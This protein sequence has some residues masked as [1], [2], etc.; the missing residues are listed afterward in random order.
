MAWDI[1]PVPFEYLSG[2]RVDF[3]LADDGHPCSFEAEFE[4]T[5]TGEQGEDVHLMAR[6]WKVWRGVAAVSQRSSCPQVRHSRRMVNAIPLTHFS[7]SRRVA[8]FGS[9]HE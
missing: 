5:D 9:V 4:T 3:D 6:G 8:V 1:R 7:V 2:V